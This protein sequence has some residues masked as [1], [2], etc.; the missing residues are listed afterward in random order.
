MK[1]CGDCGGAVIL[2]DIDGDSHSRLVCTKCEKIHYQN[3]RV[4]VGCLIHNND[5]VLLCRRR[6]NPAAGKWALPGG[7]VEC[8][9]TLEEAIAREVEEE[10]GI[11]LDECDLDLH[12]VASLHWI[13]EINIFYRAHVDHAQALAGPECEAVQFFSEDEIPWTALSYPEL[14]T[15]LN[16]FFQEVRSGKFAIS[17]TR[18]RGQSAILRRHT[19]EK[20][21]E[22]LEVNP[23]STAFTQ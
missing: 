1:F 15:Y 18:I 10:T 11:V 6:F 19:I 14:G 4:I 21:Q 3:P 17:S 5:R 22:L 13:S 8:G 2:R 20:T 12:V 16:L 7:F 23:N 9:E